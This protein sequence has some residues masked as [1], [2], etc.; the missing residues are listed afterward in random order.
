MET[1]GMW[2]VGVSK[3]FNTLTRLGKCKITKALTKIY[4][5]TLQY[6]LFVCGR[7]LEIF[8]IFKTWGSHS[9]SHQE[10]IL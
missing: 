9:V 8:S 1:W 3:L 6:L 2:T 5:L 7:C 4:A 10:V